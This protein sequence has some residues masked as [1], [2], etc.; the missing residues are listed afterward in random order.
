MF[1]WPIF[2]AKETHEHKSKKYKV[3]DKCGDDADLAVCCV[4]SYA[5]VTGPGGVGRDCA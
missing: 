4:K 3:G 5:G 2:P 1:L